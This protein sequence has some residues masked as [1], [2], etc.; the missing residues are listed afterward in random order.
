MSVRVLG[1]KEKI[2]KECDI[3]AA[4]PMVLKREAGSMRGGFSRCSTKL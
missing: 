1:K 2:S 4:V 3:L